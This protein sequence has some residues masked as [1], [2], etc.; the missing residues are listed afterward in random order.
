MLLLLLLFCA[1]YT[2]TASV[3]LGPVVE[4]SAMVRA[5]N[6]TAHG[7]WNQSTSFANE[8]SQDVRADS[9]PS[10]NETGQDLWNSSNTFLEQEFG[11]SF[12]TYNDVSSLPSNF[13]SFAVEKLRLTRQVVVSRPMSTLEQ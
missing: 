5:F 10:V 6:S 4:R 1:L 13:K 9:S 2:S 12:A 11:L 8:T 3:A 7:S